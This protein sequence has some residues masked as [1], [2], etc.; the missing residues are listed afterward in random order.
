[1]KLVWRAALSCWRCLHQLG[2]RSWCRL[3]EFENEEVRLGT[4]VVTDDACGVGKGVVDVSLAG[5][6]DGPL[7]GGSRGSDEVQRDARSGTF[8]RKGR[9]GASGV[10]CEGASTGESRREPPPTKTTSR[11]RLNVCGGR[12]SRKM[13]ARSARMSTPSERTAEAQGVVNELLREGRDRPGERAKVR[14]ET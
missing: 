12:V 8:W 6:L 3:A 11:E 5:V 13:A 14:K 2:A 10:S 9:G 4:M 7:E 1:M